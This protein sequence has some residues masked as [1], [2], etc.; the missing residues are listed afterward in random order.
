M[1]SLSSQPYEIDRPTGVCAVSGRTLEPGD[2]YIATLTEDGD[3]LKRLDI[4]LDAWEAGQRPE[5]MFSY[6][7][8]VVPEA[9]AKRKLFVDDAVL[10]NLLDRLA[11]AEQPQRIAFRF[12]LM[13]ILMRKKLLRYDRTDR[14]EAVNPAAGEGAEPMTQEWWVLT[15][16]LDLSKGPLGKWNEDVRFEVLDPHLSDEQ[17]REV[18]D[19]LGEILHAEL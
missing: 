8:A 19:Q 10:M 16:K 2:E 1:S 18:T 7:K 3:D 9:N 4:A 17:V 15:P 5:R 6:W 11:D 13:L 14:R 12:V